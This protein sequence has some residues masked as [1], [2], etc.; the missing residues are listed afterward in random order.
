MRQ[1]FVTV[2]ALTCLALCAS[3]DGAEDKDTLRVLSYNIHHGEGMD[4]RIEL[5]RIAQAIKSASPDIVSL[6]EVDNKVGRS[7]N[8]DQAK[9]LGRLM[10]MH[11]V[12]GRSI[13]LGGGQYGNAVLTKLPVQN[14]ETIPLPGKEKRSALCV[15]LKTSDKDSAGTFVFI[16]THFDLETKMQIASVPLIDK[17]FDVDKGLPAILAGDLNAGPQSPTIITFEK[18]WTNATSKKGLSTFP[19]QTPNHQ[20]D[21]ILYRPLLGCKVL[22]T[23]VLDEAVASDHRP[24]LAVLQLQSTFKKKKQTAANNLLHGIVANASNR[25]NDI[26]PPEE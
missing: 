12:F 9:E 20:V 21:Y 2:L 11:Y 25:D 6:Q 10:D 26:M 3:C 16:A 7:K 18:N 15:T 24:I 5:E 19:A 22:E 14:S 17:L 13:D 4:G 8:V 1:P 23:R